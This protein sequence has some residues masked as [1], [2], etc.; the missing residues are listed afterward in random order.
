MREFLLEIS[1]E[2][3]SNFEGLLIS[4]VTIE[5]QRKSRHSLIYPSFWQ[6][7]GNGQLDFNVSGCRLTKNISSTRPRHADRQAACGV[8]RAENA[9]R[10]DRWDKRSEPPQRDHARCNIFSGSA[11]I[12]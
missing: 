5:Y 11:A 2:R 12:E 3:K 1:R 4:C 6:R 8:G 9:R 7:T 10:I